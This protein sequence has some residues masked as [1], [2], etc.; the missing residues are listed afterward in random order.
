ARRTFT[1]CD[2]RY[3]E[4]S[5][6][7]RSIGLIRHVTLL[8]SYIGNLEPHQVH[9]RSLEPFLKARLADCASAPTINAAL[10]SC[11]R[12][13]IA[14]LAHIAIPTVV[15]SWKQCAPYGDAARKPPLALADHLEGTSP[16]EE[17]RPDPDHS[18]GLSQCSRERAATLANHGDKDGSFPFNRNPGATR[19]TAL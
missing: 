17:T 11:A 15:H 1:V 14:R 4:Q 5:R 3:V 10:K 19:E 9:D 2:A 16:W 13:S 6:G 7:K 12:S 18:A 8:Q